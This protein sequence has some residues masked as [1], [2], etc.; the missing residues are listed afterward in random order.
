MTIAT[1]SLESANGRIRLLPRR[2][3]GGR[4]REFFDLCIYA[5]HERVYV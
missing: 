2:T 3:F 4:D 5:T 1:G